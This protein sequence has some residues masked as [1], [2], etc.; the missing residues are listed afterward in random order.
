MS[1]F[2]F[3][4]LL[5]P[6]GRQ[7]LD[8]IAEVWLSGDG[9]NSA[10]DQASILANSTDEELAAQCVTG[11]GLGQAEDGRDA[12]AESHMKASGYSASD[13]TAAFGRLQARIATPSP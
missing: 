8:N 13:L 5:Y 4:G 3:Q 12:E 11:W 9:S 10:D 6:S 2:E 7:I 1:G